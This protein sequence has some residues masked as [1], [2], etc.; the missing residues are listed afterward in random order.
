MS[1][2]K[3]KSSNSQVMETV[4]WKTSLA[5]LLQNVTSW[6]SCLYLPCVDTFMMLGFMTVQGRKN[7]RSQNLMVSFNASNIFMHYKVHQHS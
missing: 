5:A 4:E 7:E 3:L 6:D 1:Q 2:V